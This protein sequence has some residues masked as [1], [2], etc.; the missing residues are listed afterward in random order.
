MTDGPSKDIASRSGSLATFFLLV[1][2]LSVPFWLIGALTGFQLVRGLPVGALMAFCPLIAAVILTYREKK[3]EGARELLGRV[4]DYGRIRNRVWYLPIVLLRPAVL[5]LSYLVMRVT[6]APLPTPHFSALTAIA[7]FA[8]FF[9]GAVGEEV[10]WSGYATDRMLSR[11]NALEAGLLLGCVM[12]VWH[13]VPLVQAHRTPTWIAWWCLS[14]VATRVL[15]IWIYNNTGGSVFATILYHDMDNVSWLM[16]P[17][18]GS[19]YDPRITGLI[20]AFAAVI[21]TLIWGSRTLSRN[22]RDYRA[23]DVMHIA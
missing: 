12:A 7:L 9:I 21:V 8:V 20:L 13:L 4:F 10:G 11:W 19:H 5:V 6:G 15:T 23:G 17:N 1:F 14:A 22:G 3:G 2:A 16:F 18:F